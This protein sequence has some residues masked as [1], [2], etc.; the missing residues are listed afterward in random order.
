MPT[1]NLRARLSH[2]PILAAPGVADCLS[3]RLVERAGFETV[4]L[5][6]AGVSYTDLGR[7]DLGWVSAGHMAERLAAISAAVSLPVIAD[8]DDGYGSAL[9]VF[10]TVELFERAGAAAIQLEDQAA[11]KRCGH[12]AGKCLVSLAEMV[13]KIAA[14]CEARRSDDLLVIART[15]ARAVEG[16]E[17]ALDRAHAYARAGADLLF[18][19]APES[20]A[21]LETIAKALPEVPLVCNMVEGGRTPLLPHRELDQIGY[22]LVLHPNALLRRYAHAGLELL[23]GL[24][25][26]GSTNGQ[27]GG[28]LLFDELQELLGIDGF[29]ELEARFGAPR[30]GEQQEEEGER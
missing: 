22:R 17:A 6:G 3:A 16:L 10:S 11:P 5:S 15:D 1:A 19:E 4:Y 8:A 30:R 23:E 2:G 13:G 18:V 9:H 25:R 14:A 12:L 28:M 20:R 21:E 26:D 27:Q 24:R 7:P 29:R